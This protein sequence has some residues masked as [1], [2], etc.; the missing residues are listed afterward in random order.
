MPRSGSAAARCQRIGV[1]VASSD[2]LEAAGGEG[3][4]YLRAARPGLRPSRLA[5]RVWGLLW[6]IP[7]GSAVV[8]A[9][10]PPLKSQIGTRCTLQATLT[11]QL[12]T[13]AL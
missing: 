8:G 2:R 12:L 1:A 11:A 6:L 7:H 10:G 5:Q 4:R 3:T 13:E 9:E